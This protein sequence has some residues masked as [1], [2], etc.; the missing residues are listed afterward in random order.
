ML[1]SLA[2][3]LREMIREVAVWLTMGIRWGGWSRYTFRF[4]EGREP[5]ELRLASRAAAPLS[6]T[7][8]HLVTL[9]WLRCPM[10][11]GG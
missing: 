7:R 6:I 9:S 11:H 1:E 2:M 10:P 5:E 3:A 8:F 4:I